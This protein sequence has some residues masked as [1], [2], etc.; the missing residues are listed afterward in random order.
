MQSWPVRYRRM[1]AAGLEPSIAKFGG[2]RYRVI[3]GLQMRERKKMPLYAFFVPAVL[4][5]LA[6][7]F[8]PS[9]K[10]VEPSK[11]SVKFTSDALAPGCSAAAIEARLMANQALPGSM[12][13]NVN[14]T[15]QLGGFRNRSITV[16][17]EN[18]IFAFTATEYLAD[19]KWNLKKLTRL[20]N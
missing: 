8:W 15:Q 18:Q 16:E 5:L 19:K 20:E 7:A 6:L 12:S 14:S 2:S 10:A 17:C 9:S 1:Q 3:A 4:V 11:S 13:V